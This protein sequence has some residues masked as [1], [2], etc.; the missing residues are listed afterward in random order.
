MP[1]N[2]S[3][4]GFMDA[5]SFGIKATDSV[6]EKA[7]F[8]FLSSDESTENV[9]PDEKEPEEKPAPPVKKPASTT[10]TE[11]TTQPVVEDK[12]DL[13]DILF[14]EEKP[15]GEETTEDENESGEENTEDG[16]DED[17]A[18]KVFSERMINLGVFKKG[19]DEQEIVIN[20]E[21]DFLNRFELET[22]KR[23]V[24]SLETFLD[25]RGEEY[26]EMFD[27]V[28]GNGVN[29]KEYL[30]KFVKIQDLSNIT[31]ETFK[32]ED[33]QEGLVRQLLKRE[34]RSAASI[35]AKIQ[36]I[37]NYGE[38]EAEATEALEILKVKEQ[39]DLRT[40]VD[41][42][43]RE[44]QFK[45]DERAKFT[46]SVNDVL[47]NKLKEAEFD[48]IPLDQPTAAKAFSLLTKE[49]Y[50]TPTGEPV[51]LFEA[52]IAELNK[53]ENRAK[54]IKMALLLDMLDTDPTLSKIQ[55]KAVTKET[56]TLFK[57]LQ[58][59]NKTTQAKKPET[60]KAPSRFLS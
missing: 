34:G 57:G 12:L 58:A 40:L 7:M 21:E 50:R 38:L 54:Q 32:Q 19:E 60:Q 59:K 25:R 23:A 47:V 9:E 45:A 13:D 30:E 51:S 49:A 14:G 17:D 42:K 28:I 35:E 39:E 18:L 2:S 43:A 6:S 55:R 22:R 37:K 11:E 41:T 53:P 31:S 27:A 16:D 15:E 33:V 8:D 3:L 20:T 46:R 10:T 5:E 56:N 24:D 48:G 26:R 1:T 4:S 29:P 52:K 44:E 36:K